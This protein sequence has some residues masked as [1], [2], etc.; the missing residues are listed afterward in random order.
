[1]KIA[2][3]N[4]GMRMNVIPRVRMLRIVTAKLMA[5]AS[6]DSDS[7]CRERIQRS[8]PLPGLYS[9]SDRGGYAVQPALDAPPFAKKLP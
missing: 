8:T 3:M 4:S 2:Q 9:V 1:M 7:R 6:D 5:P